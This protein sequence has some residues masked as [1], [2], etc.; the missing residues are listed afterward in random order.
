MKADLG[1][2]EEILEEVR[3]FIQSRAV[4][5]DVA[6]TTD[7]AVVVVRAAERRESD[8]KT[9]QAGGWIACPTALAMAQKLRIPPAELGKLL[10]FVNVKIKACSLG[11]FK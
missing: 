11:C 7:A 1:V 9:L 6:A 10:D 5:L 4:T 3:A 8:L 2:P